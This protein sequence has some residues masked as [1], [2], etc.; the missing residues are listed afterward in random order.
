MPSFPSIWKNPPPLL[1]FPRMPP[2]ETRLRP[3]EITVTAAMEINKR[4]TKIMGWVE[5]KDR[6]VKNAPSK[7]PTV[8]FGESLGGLAM[9]RGM[10]SRIDVREAMMEAPLDEV[11][12]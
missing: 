12:Q 9:T 3:R 8:D 5:M 2:R 10:V 7:M 11:S 4:I 1:P 6:V